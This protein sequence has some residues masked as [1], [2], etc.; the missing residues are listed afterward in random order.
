MATPQLQAEVTDRRAQIAEVAARAFSRVGYGS[1]SMR[2]I[3]AEVGV[4]PA[5][6]YHHY[7]TKEEILY[8]LIAGFTD[9][10]LEMIRSELGATSDP[11]AGLRR[12]LRAHIRLLETRQVETR[13]VIDEKKHLGPARLRRIVAREREVYALY[14]DAVQAII[15]SGSGRDLDPAVVSFALF[16]I[17]NY[18]YHWF[19][20][21]G[22]L[23]LGEAAEQSIALVLDGLLVGTAGSAPRRTKRTGMRAR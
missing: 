5:A 9:D 22:T 21:G 17:V 7:S 18:F 4:T 1:A 12:V 16:G 14:R 10:L 11:I 20:P 23:A 6:L 13:L 8:E 15:A 19:K 2:D 3:A